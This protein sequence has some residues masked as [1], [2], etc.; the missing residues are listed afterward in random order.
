[1][2]IDVEAKSALDSISELIKHTINNNVCLIFDPSVDITD[3]E[4]L[5][6]LNFFQQKQAEQMVTIQSL[7]TLVG[8]RFKK[9]LNLNFS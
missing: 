4:L 2:Y 5:Y 6:F 3:T 9:Q 8:E 7:I 1:M